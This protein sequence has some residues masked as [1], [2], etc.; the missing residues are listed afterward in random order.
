MA[1][2]LLKKSTTIASRMLPDRPLIAGLSGRH[3]Q[4]ENAAVSKHQSLT[5]NGHKSAPVR[6]FAVNSSDQ[7]AS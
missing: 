5:E 1:I 7:A 4:R 2:I 6:D 3:W